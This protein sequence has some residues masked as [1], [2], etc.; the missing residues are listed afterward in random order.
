MLFFPRIDA[1]AAVFPSIDLCDGSL[2]CSGLTVPALGCCWHQINNKLATSWKWAKRNTE[3]NHKKLCWIKPHWTQQE[4]DRCQN[5]NFWFH[6]LTLWSN[7]L[8]CHRSVHA[9]WLVDSFFGVIG[10]GCPWQWCWLLG[11]EQGSMSSW[12]AINVQDRW[13]RWQWNLSLG[14]G[15][16]HFKFA[17]WSS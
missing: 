14:F 13:Q 1:E 5:Q 12:G 9:A 16:R 11:L 15:D 10:I 4:N 8:F 17:A 3:N 2:C 6:V 7:F